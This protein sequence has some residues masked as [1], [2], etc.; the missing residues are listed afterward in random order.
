MVFGRDKRVSEFFS[1]LRNRKMN[2]GSGKL[3]VRICLVGTFELEVT[4]I[5][6]YVYLPMDLIA[7]QTSDCPVELCNLKLAFATV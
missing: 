1:I 4:N 7:L 3:Q 2:K 6:K 5:G